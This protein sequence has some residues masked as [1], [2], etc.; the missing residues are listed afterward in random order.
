MAKSNKCNFDSL[1]VTDRKGTTTGTDSVVHKGVL[2]SVQLH[3]SFKH[4]LRLLTK[5]CFG[6]RGVY[7]F[8]LLHKY[9]HLVVF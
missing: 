4:L 8:V 9:S 1:P 7:F 3:S 2:N 5:Q 6:E